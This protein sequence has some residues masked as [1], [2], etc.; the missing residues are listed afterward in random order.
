MN[1]QIEHLEHD[2]STPRSELLGRPDLDTIHTLGRRRRTGRRTAVAFGSVLAASV[3]ATV[4]VTGLQGGGPAPRDAQVADPSTPQMRFLVKRA[5][6][7]V[8]GAVQVSP[9]EVVVPGPGT[10]P[11]FV[12]SDDILGPE[13]FEGKTIGLGVHNYV[14]VTMY[15]HNEFPAWLHDGVAKIERDELGDPDQ[16]SYPVGSTETG[17]LVDAGSVELACMT[18]WDWNEDKQVPGKCSPALVGHV[19]DERYYM[20]GMGSDDF[21]ESGS[22][23]ELFTSDNYTSGAHSIM[24]VGGM[25]GTDVTRVDYVATDGTIVDGTISS[26]AIVPDETMFWAEMD[27]PLAKVVAYDA[28]GTVLE[29]HEIKPCDSGTDCEVR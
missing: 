3:I 24:W 28:D 21:L 10:P 1:N 29:S 27:R 6:E 9:T 18:A 19:G 2:L 23:M 26:D 11:S 16:N 4:A 7:E 22:K 17:V 5:L 20:W 14:G 12:G 13:R 15:D 25:D 8:P